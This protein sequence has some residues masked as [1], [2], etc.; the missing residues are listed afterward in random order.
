MA[1]GTYT[2]LPWLRQGIANN[3][4]TADMDA[5]VKTRASVA[6][7]LNI[8]GSGG[9]GGDITTPVVKNVALYGPGDIIGI[10]KFTA[11]QHFR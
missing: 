10:D 1:I 6:V 3:I 8:K 9:E 5:S 7:S 2:F 4:Q 11:I